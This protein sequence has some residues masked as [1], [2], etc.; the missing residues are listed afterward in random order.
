[1][2][3]SNR[4]RDMATAHGVVKFWLDEIGPEHWYVP[5][6]GLDQEIR[7]RFEQLWWDTLNGANGLW[8][9]Y[10]TGTLAYLILMDQ[11]PRNMFRG[12]AR[13]FGSDRQALAASKAALQNGWDL[14]IDEPARQFFY[15]PL[16]H[17][18]ILTD[19]DRAVRLILT[20][21]PIGKTK[22]LR[23]AQ[24]HREIIREFGRFPARNLAL[25]RKDT[26]LEVTYNKAGGYRFTLNT[27]KNA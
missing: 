15:M 11:M 18:E 14:K 19:Q 26:A 22:Q 5:S 25:S 21:L 20:R 4:G 23:H 12:S 27:I 2:K 7:D 8:L 17:S 1:M 13:S 3:L 9:S 10:A 6:Q 16:M 24:A